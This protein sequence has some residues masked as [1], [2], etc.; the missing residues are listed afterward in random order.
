VILTPTIQCTIPPYATVGTLNYTLSLVDLKN[1]KI[2]ELL[3]QFSV[4]QQEKQK[5][6]KILEEEY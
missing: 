6:I 1:P 3:T 5:A 4:Y 2:L